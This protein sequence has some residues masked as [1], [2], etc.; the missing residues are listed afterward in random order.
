M[1]QLRV[2]KVEE[3][4]DIWHGLQQSAVDSAFDGERAFAT[5]YRLKEGIFTALHGMQRGLNDEISVCPSVCPS[6]RP[7][8]RLSVKRVDCAKTAERYVQIVIAYEITFS[9]VF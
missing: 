7:S 4:L 2:H 8:V 6:V 5:A 1:Y 3:L 9:L